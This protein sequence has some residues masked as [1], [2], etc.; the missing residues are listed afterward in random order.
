MSNNKKKRKEPRK[1]QAVIKIKSCR[2]CPWLYAD[3][4]QI[5]AL[6][7]KARFQFGCLVYKRELD[8]IIAIKPDFCRVDGIVVEVKPEEEKGK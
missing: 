6:D 5:I 3:Q 7:G 8:D 1:R 4:E 2:E